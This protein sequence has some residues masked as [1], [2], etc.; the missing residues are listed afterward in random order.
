MIYMFKEVKTEASRSEINLEDHSI[1]GGTDTE[2]CSPTS[3][4]QEKFPRAL[5]RHRKDEKE[6]YSVSVPD[7]GHD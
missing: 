4:P 2:T 7:L 6:G 1:S 3:Q 5:V